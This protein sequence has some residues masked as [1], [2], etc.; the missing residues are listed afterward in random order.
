MRS[1]RIVR[2]NQLKNVTWIL[3]GLSLTIPA[4]A[5]QPASVN[6]QTLLKTDASWDGARY[7]SYPSGRPQISVLRI[8]IPPHTSLPWHT[9]PMPNAAYVLGGELTVEKPDGGKQRITVGQVLPETVGT[10][11]R[12]VTGDNPV[13]LIVFYAGSDGLPLSERTDAPAR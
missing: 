11:H 12:G 7:K 13:T 9:H 3:V 6:V 5:E 10:V 1:T 8:E 4:L 2:T